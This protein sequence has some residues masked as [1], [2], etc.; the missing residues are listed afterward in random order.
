MPQWNMQKVKK[1]ETP[2][3]NKILDYSCNLYTTQTVNE[4][5]LKLVL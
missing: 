2:K 4:H 5:Y 3:K 1:P